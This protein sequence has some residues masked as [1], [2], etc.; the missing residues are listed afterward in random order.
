MVIFQI[1]L[2]QN[3]NFLFEKTENKLKE[4]EDGP[5]KKC[6]LLKLKLL[7]S[8]ESPSITKGNTEVQHIA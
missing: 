1:N 8:Y 6:W 3:G 5:L 7:D 4:A 2:L